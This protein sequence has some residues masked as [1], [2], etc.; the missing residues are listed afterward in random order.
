MAP[1]EEKQPECRAGACGDEYLST[2]FSTWLEQ[3]PYSA[4][5]PRIVII[6]AG[7]RGRTYANII[8]SFTNGVVVAVAEPDEYK[9]M[10]LGEAVIWGKGNSP[11][12]GSSFADWR[13]FIEY[14]RCRRARQESGEEDVPL[15]VDAAFVCV[16]DEMHREVVLELVKLGGLHIMCEK[17]LATTLSDCL[18]MYKA[19]RHNTTLDGQQALFSIGH[20]LRYT[21]HNMLLRK[22]LLKDRVI[23]DVLSVVHTE[24]VGWWHFAHSYVRGNW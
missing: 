7:S 17:P 13:E 16:L 12:E 8:K 19:L 14:E 24:P 6:G 20:V 9:R 11:P 4:N 3:A 2:S 18:D 22:L 1:A 21:P 15:G 5:P 10:C 23:G